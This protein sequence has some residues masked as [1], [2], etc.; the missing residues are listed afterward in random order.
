MERQ[1]TLLSADC[2]GGS[3]L[4]CV[5]AV[6][7]CCIFPCVQADPSFVRSAG[8]GVSGCPGSERIQNTDR[9]KESCSPAE[10]QGD[11]GK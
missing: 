7:Y 1:N 2:R 3:F 6:S 8:K 11:P 5:K 4:L 10:H 9:S